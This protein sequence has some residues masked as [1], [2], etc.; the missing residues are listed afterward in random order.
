MNVQIIGE[1]N[2]GGVMEVN[3]VRKN[4]GFIDKSKSIITLWS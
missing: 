1:K 4:E 2:R 3:N